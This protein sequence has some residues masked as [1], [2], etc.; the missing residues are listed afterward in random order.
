MQNFDAMQ[1][2][3]DCER[4]GMESGAT[5]RKMPIQRTTARLQWRDGWIREGWR[6]REQVEG[7]T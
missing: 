4:R 6:R 7:W 5:Q 2:D 1:R 3:G